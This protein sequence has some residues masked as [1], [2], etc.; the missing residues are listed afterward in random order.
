[1]SLPSV[2]KLNTADKVIKAVIFDLDGTLL[3]TLGDLCNSVNYALRKMGWKERT[4]EEVRHFVGNGVRKLMERSVPEGTQKEDLER[5]FAHFQKHYLVHCQDTT[6][7]YPG[8]GE[9]L[10]EVHEMGLRTAIVSNKL[11]A[12]VDE[13]YEKFFRDV[14][15]VAI[16]QRNDVPLKPAP[17]MVHLAIKE[18]EKM[19]MHNSLSPIKGEQDRILY[20]GDSEVDVKTARN[21]HLPF[22]AVLWGFRTKDELLHAGATQ[23]I[24]EPLSLICKL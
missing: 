19:T 10:R 14:V 4:L 18:L 6:D 7:L 8:V 1:M 2:A 13:L 9:M 16:G 5:C 24:S 22:V 3:N 15:D 20:V 11:Q 21:A 23:F 12:G 17:D